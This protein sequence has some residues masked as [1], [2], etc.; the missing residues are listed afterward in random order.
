M[1]KNYFRLLA[2]AAMTAVSA[3]AFAIDPPLKSEVLTD[4][5]TYL[6]FSYAN[7]S[8]VLSRTSWD[9]AYYLLDEAASN[10]LTGTGNRTVP[11]VAHKA[12]D[13]SWYFSVEENEMIT[14]VSRAVV[15]TC[16]ATWKN[17]SSG[18]WRMH[19]LTDSIC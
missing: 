13:G 19:L 15:E 11:F 7:P 17:R 6:L 1:K 8:K 10:Y 9:G 2:I 4:G 5:N 14:W 16:M 12:D 18:M 3:T